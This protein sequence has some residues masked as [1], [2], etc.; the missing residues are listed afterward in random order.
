MLQ[1]TLLA[2]LYTVNNNILDLED[3]YNLEIAMTADKKANMILLRVYNKHKLFERTNELFTEGNKVTNADKYNK[4]INWCIKKA[5]KHVMDISQSTFTKHKIVDRIESFVVLYD[6]ITFTIYFDGL[7]NHVIYKT[8]ITYN[9][10]IMKIGEI[11]FDPATVD[12]ICDDL[13]TN[14]ETLTIGRI[15]F[16]MINNLRHLQFASN[17]GKTFITDISDTIDKVKNDLQNF[18]RMLDRIMVVDR[19]DMQ[20]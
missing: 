11:V 18:K 1:T 13:S 9:D 17:D 19:P 12:I 2:I 10:S 15:H 4:Y 14:R 3:L 16:P 6:E 7:D 8:H 5:N 20:D